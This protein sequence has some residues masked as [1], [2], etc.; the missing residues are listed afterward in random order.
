MRVADWSVVVTGACLIVMSLVGTLVERVKRNKH[1]EQGRRTRSLWA[2]LPLLLFGLAEIMSTL[3][4]LLGASH[5][6]RMAFDTANFPVVVGA[7]IGAVRGLRGLRAA[8][9]AAGGPP[10]GR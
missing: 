10:A 9:A 7:V 5:A 3:P 2:W 1:P 6:V 4:G 8:R